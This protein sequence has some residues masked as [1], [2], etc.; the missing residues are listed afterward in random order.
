MQCMKHPS[1]I[2]GMRLVQKLEKHGG[3][4]NTVSWN[5]DASLLIS[6]SDDMT[7]VVWSTGTYFPVKGSVF[8]GHTHNVFDAQFV[9]NCNSTKCVTTAADGQVR[10]TVSYTHLTLPT[11]YS[12]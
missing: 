1:I 2:K 11:I 6:G 10:M 7:V 8:T 3:C 12:V 5:E 4:V 9:P